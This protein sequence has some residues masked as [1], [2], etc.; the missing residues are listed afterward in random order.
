LSTLSANGIA[1]RFNGRAVLDDIS[2]QLDT[3]ELLG[4]IG[5]NG[6][7]KTTCLRV[8]LNLQEI[9]AGRIDLD[10][11]PIRQFPRTELARRIAYMPQ[12]GDVY[13]PLT[14][15]R[16]VALGRLP[17]RAP[18]RRIG[19]SD[20]EV[21]EHAMH[22]A[23]VEHLRHRIITTLSGGERMLV[24]LARVMAG[25]PEMIMAD[26]PTASL[27]P[28]HQLQVMEML[29]MTARR[30]GA[31]LVVLHDLTLAARYCDRLVLLDRGRVAGDGAPH[32]ILVD[33]NLAATYRVKAL[34]GSDGDQR[35]IVPW[36]MIDT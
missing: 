1:V 28:Y 11:C 27:D 6:S 35:F 8:L 23:D 16:V 30:G 15:E 31:V 22:E 4:L 32:D 13:W 2:L 12:G 24:H 9:Q 20:L 14:V 25:E 17:H 7:G 10:G 19:G 29:K 33:K 18:W 5:P 34:R 21:I 3:G 36:Q 26:E